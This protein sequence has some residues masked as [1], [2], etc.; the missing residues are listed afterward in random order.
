MASTSETIKNANAVVARKKAEEISFWLTAYLWT[1]HKIAR[2]IEK[3]DKMG[4][5]G[6][7]TL[8]DEVSKQIE[9]W[10]RW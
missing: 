9:D 3:G 2:C 7:A 1:V 4:A 8:Q 10:K 6:H 5:I